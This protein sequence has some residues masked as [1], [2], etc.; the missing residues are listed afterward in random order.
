LGLALGLTLNK[1][2]DEEQEQKVEVLNSYDNTEELIKTFQVIN[3]TRVDNGLEKFI[4]N[5]LLTGFA[6]WNRGFE[7]WKE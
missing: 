1:D 6:N 5:L 4:Q 3:P 2:D 7:T